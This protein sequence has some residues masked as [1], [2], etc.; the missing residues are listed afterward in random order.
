MHHGITP[1]L[2]INE[3]AEAVLYVPRE[4]AEDAKQYSIEPLLGIVEN[5]MDVCALRSRQATRDPY[6]GKETIGQHQFDA[7]IHSLSSHAMTRL[8]KRSTDSI[9]DRTVLVPEK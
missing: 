6:A 2:R 3:R 7:G 9:L 5:G 1:L 4:R 8:S